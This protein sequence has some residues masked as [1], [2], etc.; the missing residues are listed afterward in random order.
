M[1]ESLLRILATFA[2][3]GLSV[4]SAWAQ[5]PGRIPTLSTWG[6]IV[7]GGG[8]AVAGVRAVLR[9]RSRD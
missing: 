7:L 1:R 3:L 4:T 2:I 8:L 9:R 5:T 6:L